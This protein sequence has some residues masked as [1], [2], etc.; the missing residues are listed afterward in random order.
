MD[1]IRRILVSAFEFLEWMVRY[2]KNPKTHKYCNKGKRIVIVGNGPSASSFPYDRFKDSGY[3]FCC[4]NFFAFDKELFFKIKPRYYCCIDPALGRENINR[5]EKGKE[6]VSIL[7]SVDWDMIFVCLKNNKF[8]IENKHICFQFINNNC[9]G[10][11][12]TELK[13][14]LFNN[15]FASCG[16]QNVIV[17]CIY[18]FI[19]S[20]ADKIILT[21]VE[22]DWHR[23]LTVN[24]DN[25]VYRNDTHFYG[26]DNLN[27]TQI[28]EI[29]KGKLY[30][31]FYYYYITLYEYAMLA[32]YAQKN[33]IMIENSCPDSFIDTFKKVSLE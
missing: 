9:Y 13:N 20:K 21:G 3:V 8:D 27:L 5:S 33:G 7:N 26:S 32:E 16:F 17:A 1:K 18:Y 2:I 10:G 11:F 6:L 23:E 4:V 22:N 24:M 28:G 31:Y 19:M 29:E 14:Y 25:E 15:N 12:I 30:K